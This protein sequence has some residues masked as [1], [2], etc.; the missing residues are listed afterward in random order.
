ML[1]LWLIMDMNTRIHN[2]ICWLQLIQH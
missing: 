1:S 2:K